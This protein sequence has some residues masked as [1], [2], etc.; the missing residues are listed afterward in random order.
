MVNFSLAKIPK[1][2]LF[3]KGEVPTVGKG[4]QKGNGVSLTRILKSTKLSLLQFF[5]KIKKWV[6]MN[7][8]K[9]ELQSKIDQLER[10]FSVS[11][12]IFKVGFIKNL[13]FNA[14]M[15]NFF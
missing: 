3:R 2:L 6:D 7:H 1:H 14:H 13:F 12:V 10:N 5:I 8:M 9:K 15:L 4:V 11:N